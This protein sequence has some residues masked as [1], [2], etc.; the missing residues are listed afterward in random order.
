MDIAEQVR[1]LDAMA[2]LKENWDSYGGK[3]ISP[4]AIEWAKAVL[5]RLGP[6]WIPVPCSD[7]GVQLEWHA[8]GVD[9]EMTI[10]VAEE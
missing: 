9:M 7:G 1:Q 5:Y 8:E 3:P 2:A 10:A 4:V 6:G